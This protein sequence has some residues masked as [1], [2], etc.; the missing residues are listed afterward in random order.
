MVNAVAWTRQGSEL[1]VD[2]AAGSP[3]VTVTQTA[4]F[5]SDGGTLDVGGEQVG[6]D[7][8]DEDTGIIVL[9]DP[10]SAAATAGD[11]VHIIS[12]GVQAIDYLAF[13]SLGVGDELEVSIPFEQRDMWPEGE[14]DNPVLVELSNDLRSIT[15]VPGRTP[16]RDGS[17]IDPTT[18]PPV[19]ISTDGLPPGQSPPATLIGGIGALFVRWPPII[20]HDPVT[21]EVHLSATAGFTPDETT[22]VTETPGTSATVR[23]TAD[24]SPLTYLDADGLTATVY[25]AAIVARDADGAATPGAEG[26]ASLMQVTG[27]DIAA[28]YVYAGTIVADKIEGGTLRSDVTIAASLKTGEHGRRVELDS[29]GIILWAADDTTILARLPTDP[30]LSASIKGH[31][32]LDTATVNDSLTLNGVTELVRG[33]T[34]QLSGKINNPTT[35]PTVAVLWPG[36]PTALT[37]NPA[38]TF[39]GWTWYGDE[40]CWASVDWTDPPRF[41]LIDP[42]TGA[43]RGRA[44]LPDRP[45]THTFH[46]TGGVVHVGG[47]FITVGTALDEADGLPYW[48]ARKYALPAGDLTGEEDPVAVL[49]GAV[50]LGLSDGSTYGGK[51]PRIGLDDT[52]GTGAILVAYTAGGMLTVATLDPATLTLGAPVTVGGGAN[53]QGAAA[54]IGYAQRGTFDFGSARL[55]VSHRTTGAAF[56]V[57]NGTARSAAEDWPTADGGAA[58]VAGASYGPD[59]RFHALDT[60]GR[61]VT[62]SAIR[63][64]TEPSTWW[65]AYTWRDTDPAGTGPHET[66]CSVKASFTM[67]QRAA[68]KIT[69][70]T[71]PN[72]PDIADD[73]DSV[74]LYLGRSTSP[75]G[76]TDSSMFLAAAPPAGVRSATFEQVTFAGTTAAAA[77]PAFPI[78]APSQ[79]TD[80]VG[81]VLVDSTG[82]SMFAP[83]GVMV[84]YSGVTAPGGWLMCDGQ[85]YPRSM[86]PALYAVIKDRYGTPDPAGVVFT[87]PNMTGQLHTISPNVACNVIVKT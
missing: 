56:A 17:F 53:P 62:H 86:Y 67:P 47:E 70:P 2:A 51:R 60:Y 52:G 55:V 57:Y 26:A 87:V 44:L 49:T 50:T 32:E 42:D 30:R 29:G 24:G 33:S 18:L 66:G 39:D 35:P 15:A 41:V 74:G 4:D 71:I 13:V 85:T 64:T 81:N 7:T 78:A 58:T 68:L 5:D 20:N 76:P 1:E 6:Y 72:D 12:G 45:G 46:A 28:G 22:L 69:A 82:Y 31:A 38:F 21:Y 43:S 77:G 63:Y 19:T 34:L 10:L 48:E 40:S 75:A 14:Y 16:V 23:T 54:D 80:S 61:H 8:V 36:V 65:A 11:W 59:G 84:P 37:A 83:T 79:V 3:T 27:P 9:S 25:H 73:P